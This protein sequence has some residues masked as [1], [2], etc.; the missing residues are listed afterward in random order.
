MVW[1]QREEIT[2]LPGIKC[3]RCLESVKTAAFWNDRQLGQVSYI[4]AKRCNLQFGRKTG[5]YVHRT[6][7]YKRTYCLCKEHA[8][9][10]RWFHHFLLLG[11]NWVGQRRSVRLTPISSESRGNLATRVINV[12]CALSL[13]PPWLTGAILVLC[14]IYNIISFKHQCRTTALQTPGFI[15]HTC[16][17]ACELFVWC[18]WWC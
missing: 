5:R 16:T 15:L 4:L 1:R 10:F 17:L 3:M 6:G 13:P 12:H 8:T 2:R 14:T 9:F 11:R 7:K 18:L